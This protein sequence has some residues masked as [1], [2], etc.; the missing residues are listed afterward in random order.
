[1]IGSMA[2]AVDAQPGCAGGLCVAKVIRADSMVTETDTTSAWDAD[3]RGRS[4]V[5]SC[6]EIASANA[7]RATST[8]T[9]RADA[10]HARTTRAG[11]AT[12]ARPKTTCRRHRW[13]LPFLP[14]MVSTTLTITWSL[15]TGTVYNLQRTPGV[16]IG[17]Q[18]SHN[19]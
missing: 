1:M 3:Q 7:M 14:P 8:E 6:R 4:T 18:Y 19:R 16:T 11:S 9:T 17:I 12:A 5:I 10:R 15:V 13:G 2:H